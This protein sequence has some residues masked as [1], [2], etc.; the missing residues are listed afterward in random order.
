MTSTSL[1]L[2]WG[3]PA[4]DWGTGILSYQI[5]LLQEGFQQWQPIVQQPRNYFVVKT[6]EP[7]TS[8]QFR[9]SAV[10]Y[11][12]FSSPSEASDPVV[13]KARGLLSASPNFRKTSAGASSVLSQEVKG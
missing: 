1:K 7:S 5:E 6:L 9:V 3:P 8:Y 2:K 11:H 13:T 4:I 12:G 10:N